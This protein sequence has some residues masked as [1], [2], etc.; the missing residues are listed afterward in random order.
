[1][2]EKLQCFVVDLKI[3]L[4]LLLLVE[5]LPL[6]SW[7]LL[8][9]ASLRRLTILIIIL[10][11]VVHYVICIVLALH[12]EQRHLLVSS[13]SIDSLLQTVCVSQV[14]LDFLRQLQL[15]TLMHRSLLLQSLYN[16]QSLDLGQKQLLELFEVG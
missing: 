9:G 16:V 12:V 3:G 10:L 15:E 6:G 14:L 8:V 4:L 5:V 7:S 13:E 1:V 2:S 11:C